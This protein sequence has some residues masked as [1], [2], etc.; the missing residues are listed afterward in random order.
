MLTL[1]P[2][3]LPRPDTLQVRRS[4]FKFAHARLRQR[5]FFPM[6]EHFDTEFMLPP[7][8]ISHEKDFKHQV[9]S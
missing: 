6:H 3:R 1:N 5:L 8:V 7:A 9:I 4:T 2:L